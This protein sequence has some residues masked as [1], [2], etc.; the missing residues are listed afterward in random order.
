MFV[1]SGRG[2][3]RTGL[4]QEDHI[5]RG[6]AQPAVAYINDCLF[7]L[8]SNAETVILPVTIGRCNAGAITNYI[9]KLDFLK[10]ILF[11]FIYFSKLQKTHNDLIRAITIWC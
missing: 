10:L 5:S 8:P 3:S 7:R 6:T 1:W 9:N 2:E 4:D 11:N